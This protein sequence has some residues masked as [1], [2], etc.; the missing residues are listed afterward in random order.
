[1]EDEP[2]NPTLPTL[3][4]RLGFASFNIDELRIVTSRLAIALEMM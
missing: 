3:S 2:V 4:L 1:M